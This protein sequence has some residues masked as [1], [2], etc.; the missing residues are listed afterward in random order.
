MPGAGLKGKLPAGPAQGLYMENGKCHR[1]F[2]Q[3]LSVWSIRQISLAA[4]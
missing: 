4:S 1:I 2:Q 3:G